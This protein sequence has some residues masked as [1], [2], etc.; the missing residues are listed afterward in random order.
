M[1]LLVIWRVPFYSM[2]LVHR[3]SH[4]QACPGSQSNGADEPRWA[5]SSGTKTM[6]G[7]YPFQT[8]RVD[9][10]S[11]AILSSLSYQCG[12]RALMWLASPEKPTSLKQTRCHPPFPTQRDVLKLLALITMSTILLCKN[13]A[14]CFLGPQSL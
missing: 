11:R 3:P 2:P 8:V 6:G 13:I 9:L 10:A 7:T 14:N 1:F 4:S 12:G 5:V